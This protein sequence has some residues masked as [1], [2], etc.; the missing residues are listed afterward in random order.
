MKLI[1]RVIK[2]VDILEEK[3]DRLLVEREE[4]LPLKTVD[5]GF[6][7]TPI[8]NDKEL[9]TVTKKIQHEAYYKENLV[10]FSAFFVHE[11]LR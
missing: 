9:Q 8:S 5:Y 3:L 1:Y 11:R 4:K 2:K 10:C 6:S 7:F